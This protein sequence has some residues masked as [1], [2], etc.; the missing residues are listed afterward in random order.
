MKDILGYES[1]YAVTKD[2]RVWSYPRI[3]EIVNGAKRSHSGMFLKPFLTGDKGQQYLVVELSNGGVKKNHRIHT[4]VAQTYIPNPANLPVVN[5]K[6]GN[7]L[8][9]RMS[10]LEWCTQA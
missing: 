7:R 3:W 8:N 2:G 6:D 4:L 10:N 9:N 1:V 5:H